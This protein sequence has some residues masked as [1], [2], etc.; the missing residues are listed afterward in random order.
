MFDDLRMASQRFKL[1][2]L[3]IIVIVLLVSGIGND[4]VRSMIDLTSG[5][6]DDLPLWLMLVYSI[7]VS[8]LIVLGACNAT[9]LIDGLDGLCSG[10]VAII[11]AGLLVLA[12]HCHLWG[13]WRSWDVLRVVVTLSM[14][15]AALGFLPYNRHPAKI[16]MGDAGSMLLGLNV[17]IVLLI[18]AKANA[19]RYLLA[20]IMVFG[21]P[22]ADTALAMARR[23]R[24]G[25]PIMQGD[26]SH[27]YDQL[28]D[29]GW[30]VRCVVLVSYS[31]CA[32][33]AALGCLAIAVRLRYLIPL[34]AMVVVG[35]A[36]LVSRLGMVDV[37]SRK[38]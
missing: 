7:P 20:S 13:D 15:G 29:R 4:T 9:N 5:G 31:A 3:S 25:K 2:G 30:S 10:V 22:I 18:F 17:A 23:W 16:F 21:L 24:N 32:L 14:M 33:F 28:I 37:E 19:L 35:V 26:R 36:I 38:K 6:V 27:F 1:L 8:L 34:Y 12:I 11:S